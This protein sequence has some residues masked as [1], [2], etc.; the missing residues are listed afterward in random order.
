MSAY[1]TTD[2]AETGGR[3]RPSDPAGTRPKHDPEDLLPINPLRTDGPTEEELRLGLPAG[4]EPSDYEPFHAGGTALI[5]R[6]LESP[7]R[8][9]HLTPVKAARTDEVPKKDVARFQFVTG[10]LVAIGVAVIVLAVFLATGP[11]PKKSP[12]WS[13]W[14][15][16]NNGEDPLDQIAQHVG[17]EYRLPGGAQIVG[18]EAQ[19]LAQQGPISILVK[20]ASGTVATLDGNLALY[21]LCGLG[22]GCSIA[23]GSPSAARGLLIGREALELAL[24]TFKYDSNID[25]VMVTEPPTA[26]AAAADEASAAT[27]SQGLIPNGNP[28][29]R[30][31][32]IQ[33]GQLSSELDQPLA[34]SLASTTPSIATV[35]ASPDYQLVDSFA[36][37]TLYQFAIE[38]SDLGSQ[39]VLTPPTTTSAL[40]GGAAAAVGG[41]GG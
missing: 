6:P 25:D 7:A 19:D 11:G 38:N 10:A 34:Q 23:S 32:F 12:P 30:A 27:S 28:T 20:Q 4:T 2:T 37:G 16:A 35:T 18:V 26:A 24:Y 13:A 31:F 3:E 29:D 9:D 21:E 1:E 14:S 15:P 36:T 8:E 41:T 33:R 17:P 22:K 5:A 39:L 40:T